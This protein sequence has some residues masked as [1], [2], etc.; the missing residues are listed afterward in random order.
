MILIVCL[1]Y[2]AGAYTEIKG[3]LKCVVL[4]VVVSKVRCGTLQSVCEGG[5]V[6]RSSVRTS[7]EANAETHHVLFAS[8][9]TIV[10]VSLVSAAAA[11]ARAAHGLRP[12]QSLA[13]QLGRNRILKRR[14]RRRSG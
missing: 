4:Y 6:Q 7:E 12:L 14:R 13:A 10:L 1:Q 8:A 9:A 3:H 5:A 11:A 2:T